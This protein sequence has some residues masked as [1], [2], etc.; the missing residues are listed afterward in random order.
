M[1][2]EECLVGCREAFT[3]KEFFSGLI[4]CY[5]VPTK[6]SQDVWKCLQHFRGE[7]KISRM[8]ADRAG[9]ILKACTRLGIAKEPSRPGE[10]RNNSVVERLNQI[11]LT[12]ARAALDCAGL[13]ACFWTFAVECFCL[14]SN[15]ET[16]EGEDTMSPWATPPGSEFSGPRIPF[17]AK[18][19]LFPASTKRVS[20]L[21]WSGNMRVGVFAGYEIVPGYSWS[22]NFLVWDLDD[23]VGVC[24]WRLMLPPHL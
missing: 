13:P 2:T 12:S 9:E 6:S 1:K 4:H 11:I 3:I 10:P 21:K 8:Y 5:P 24:A 23:F 15:F 17:G 16:P 20:D 19:R 22:G 14:L 18:V 7:R